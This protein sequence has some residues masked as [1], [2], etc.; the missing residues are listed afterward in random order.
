[1][2]WNWHDKTEQDSPVAKVAVIEVRYTDGTTIQLT[3]SEEFA[4]FVEMEVVPDEKD[5][6]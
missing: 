6:E 3:N 5:D 4:K 1:M 2:N